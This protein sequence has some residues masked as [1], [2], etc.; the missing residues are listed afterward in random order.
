MSEARGH[1]A[2]PGEA[3]RVDAVVL[4][5]RLNEGTFREVSQATNEALLEMG[6]RRMLDFVLDALRGAGRVGRV[7]AVATPDV[8]PH[9]PVDV[10]YLEAGG[11]V[12]DNVVRGVTAFGGDRPV[13]IAT[14]DI[15]FITPAIVDDFVGQCLATPADLYYP[16]IPR[17]DAEARFPG[18]ERTYAK[19]RDGTFTGGNMFV[20]TP[21][22]VRESAGRV[23][24]F[25]DARKSPA[26]MASMIGPGFVIGLLMGTLSIAQLEA[27]VGAMFGA[28]GKVIITRHAE[29]GVDVDKLSDLE[30]ARRVLGG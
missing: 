7:L 15:P 24:A 3:Q 1:A 29:I 28:R 5:G 14:S 6:G 27:K 13:L 18:V 9:L 30:L 12:I 25:V 11:E 26:K 19:L 4:A 22:L 20:V 17:V 23:R 21:R 16:A 10:A 2:G 8:R